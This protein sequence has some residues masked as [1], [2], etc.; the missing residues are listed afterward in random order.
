MAARADPLCVFPLHN[1]PICVPS[2]NSLG[3]ANELSYD[4]EL[5]RG[6]EGGG[7]TGFTD[8]HIVA[9]G[10]DSGAAARAAGH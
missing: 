1:L 6:V 9:Y 3:D 2:G 5:V 7:G 4:L 10:R 8:F